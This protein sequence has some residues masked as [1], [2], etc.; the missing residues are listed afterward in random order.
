MGLLHTF[1]EL[2]QLHQDA[3][4][5]LVQTERLLHILQRLLLASLLVIAGQG[6]IT[7]YGG[8]G[9][10]FL[11]RKLPVLDGYIILSFVV[12]ETA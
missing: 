11:C 6:E 9:G 1:I 2:V 3:T 12:I 10:V 8:E 4:V 5:A 7:P